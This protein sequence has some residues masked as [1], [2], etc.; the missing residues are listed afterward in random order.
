MLTRLLNQLYFSYFCAFLCR[1]RRV[2]T[3]RPSPSTVA[4]SWC[5]PP[6]S[7][8]EL[9]HRHLATRAETGQ[10][11]SLHVPQLRN[12]SQ[13]PCYQPGRDS[14]K[15]KAHLSLSRVQQSLRQDFTP[16]S[17]PP[18]AHWGETVHLWL[19]VLWEKVHTLRRV[20]ATYPNSH[21]RE[22]VQV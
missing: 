20:T 2:Y 14:Q 15:E 17:T 6:T 1:R 10:E 21:R 18:L 11:S 13:C 5:S 3:A 4:G 9:L 7:R 16:P 22:A 12:G 8:C 19:A